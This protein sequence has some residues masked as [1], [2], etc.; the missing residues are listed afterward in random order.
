MK[1]YKFIKL[2]ATLV[3]LVFCCIISKVSAYDK[4]ISGYGNRIGIISL[5]PKNSGMFFDNRGFLLQNS[6]YKSLFPRKDVTFDKNV[7]SIIIKSLYKHLSNIYNDTNSF[8]QL[9]PLEPE[10]HQEGYLIEGWW[11]VDTK[12]IFVKGLNSFFVNHS[13]NSIVAVVPITYYLP[14]LKSEA[15]GMNLTFTKNKL[16]FSASY[17]ILIF[18]KKAGGYEKTYSSI[19]QV[20]CDSIELEDWEFNDKYYEQ[21]HLD[22][23]YLLFETGFLSYINSQV[24]K[25]LGN[26]NDKGIFHKPKKP[27]RYF[28]P[29]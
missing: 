26:K 8:I 4:K 18:S 7:N 9:T 21:K 10:K 20:Y 16:F 15:S 12:S 24:A 2:F 29:H 1:I 5:F 13:L 23:Y 22:S 25:L 6:E 3:V 17:A 28:M 11:G 19:K 14:A 27:L